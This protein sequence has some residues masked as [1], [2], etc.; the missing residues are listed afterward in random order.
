MELANNIKK[1]RKQMDW[2]QA[3]LAEKLGLTDKAVSSWERGR[4]EPSIGYVEKMSRLFQVSKSE[5][6]GLPEYYMST[7][8]IKL[9]GKNDPSTDHSHYVPVLG[10]VAAGVP[11][12]MVEDV[13]GFEEV[14]DSVGEAFA[15][16]IDGDSMEPLLQRGDVVI[17]RR[18]EDVESG[19]VA[20]VSVDGEDA[21]CKR[22]QKTEAGVMLVSVN[23]D[24]PPRFFS[25]EEIEA[26]PVRIL[27][28]V[29]ESRRT[30]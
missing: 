23:P 14:D 24:Y 8:T 25:N 5:L 28:R 12:E 29:V 22:I 30:F 11:I 17:V 2:S 10:R 15:L 13:L 26:L 7:I 6:L 4:T 9:P 16:K 19:D 3:D 27:G 21:T 20:I 18:Q 1:Y